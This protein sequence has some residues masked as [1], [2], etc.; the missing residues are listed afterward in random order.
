MV[1]SQPE[2]CHTS[3]NAKEQSEKL[4][5]FE[6]IGSWCENIEAMEKMY[7][8]NQT[9]FGQ[10]IDDRSQKLLSSFGVEAKFTNIFVKIFML[11]LIQKISKCFRNDT[12][13]RNGFIK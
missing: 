6:E 10:H 8:N 1:A 2:K 9:L 11:H 12:S 3:H 13:N 5:T 4:T 7:I